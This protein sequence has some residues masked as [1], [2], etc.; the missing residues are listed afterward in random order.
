MGEQGTSSRNPSALL[1]KLKA[2][3]LTI[4]QLIDGLASPHADER[5][6]AVAA[7]SIL[8]NRYLNEAARAANPKSLV[9]PK[10]DAILSAYNT[11]AFLRP[12]DSAILSSAD[13]NISFSPREA[14]I[15]AI[16]APPPGI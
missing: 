5:R 3:Q 4:G 10:D 6:D 9:R 15:S 11:L 14:S 8:R 7:I 12:S 2:S 16:S 13:Q 1:Q